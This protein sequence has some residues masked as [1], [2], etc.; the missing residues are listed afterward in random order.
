MLEEAVKERNPDVRKEAVTAMSLLPVSDKLLHQLS[1]MLDDHDVQVRVAVV[2]TLGDFTDHRTVPLLQKALH[3]PVPEVSF[4]AAKILLDRHQPDGERFLLEVVSGEAR[5]S[6]SYLTSERRNTLRLL[7][8]PTTL[9]TTVGPDLATMLFPLPG[10][11]LGLSS[12]QGILSEPDS[13]TRAAALLL[14][15]HTRDPALAD[16][17]LSAL[18]AKEWPVRAAAAHVIA[19]HPFPQYRDKLVGLLDDKKE[20][21]RLRA[22]AAYLRLQPRT[23]KPPEGNAQGH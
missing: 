15:E 8:T 13:T 3:D 12:L 2:S 1:T 4:G 21:V 11:G 14:L 16:A 10:L 22:A 20:P 23:K 5:G 18:S 9:F 7:Q 17:V 19:V 6:S